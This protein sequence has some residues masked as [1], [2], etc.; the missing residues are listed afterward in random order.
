M[1][2]V[3][4]CS[5]LVS[6]Q[7]R[8]RIFY[9]EVLGFRIKHDFPVDEA[10]NAWLTVTSPAAPNGV[11]LLLE[12]VH[13]MQTAVVFQQ[14]RYAKGIPAT[15]WATEDIDAEYARLIALG[16]TFK[17][18]PAPTGPTRGCAFDDT[19]GNWIQLYKG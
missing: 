6:D 19:C 1:I 7:A 15:M 14:D 4:L 3:K 8:A 12:P 16:V 2:Q 11:E 9:T 18:S 17:G 5:V 10:G 13:G